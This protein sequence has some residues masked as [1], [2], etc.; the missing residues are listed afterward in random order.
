MRAYGFEDLVPHRLLVYRAMEE[1]L[2][3]FFAP[4]EITA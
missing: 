3:R 2:D 1:V 4:N